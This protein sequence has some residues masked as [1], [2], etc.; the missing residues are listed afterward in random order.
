MNYEL[1]SFH[2]IIN[3]IDQKTNKMQSS[4]LNYCMFSNCSYVTFI[5]FC[6][7][8]FSKYLG[9]ERKNIFLPHMR[10]FLYKN[11]LKIIYHAI[12]VL[13]IFQNFQYTEMEYK[14][15]NLC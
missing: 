15:T 11:N 14:A 5:W 4:N 12:N 6:I 3:N 8:E 2:S 13:S 9:I 10:R 1:W 7:I